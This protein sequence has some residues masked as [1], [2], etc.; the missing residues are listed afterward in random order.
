MKEYAA[1]K[2][3]VYVETTIVS[4][5]TSRP[6]NDAVI[7]SRQEATKQLWNEY[8]DNFEFMVS[9]IVVSEIERGD[10]GE[11]QRRLNA[12]ANLTALQTSPI[13]DT[14]A[15]ELI[16]ADAVPHN[17]PQD[18]QHIAIATVHGLDYLISWNHKHIVSENKRQ[19]INRVC[20]AAGYQP[21]IICTPTDI[22]EELRMKE[23]FELPT[24]PI[25]EECYR[26]KEEFAAQFSS[27]EELSAYLKEIEKREKAHGRKFISPPPPP[28]EPHKKNRG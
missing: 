25:L 14:L 9:V 24:D 7:F 2:P 18:A 3:T 11:A 10:P 17:S 26:M 20:S 27:M 22:I 1:I 23:K 4:Y 12:V 13:S 8:S 21:T 19:H 15:Q 28:S 16:D 6:S 5:L